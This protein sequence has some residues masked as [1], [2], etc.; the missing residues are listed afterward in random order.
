MMPVK[1]SFPKNKKMLKLFFCE[2]IHFF[3]HKIICFFKSKLFLKSLYNR[4]FKY[5]KITALTSIFGISTCLFIPLH[6]FAVTITNVL[7]GEQELERCR[8]ELTRLEQ[9]NR[10]ANSAALAKNCVC[11]STAPPTDE[12][13]TF[14][15][16]RN[17]TREQYNT[18]SEEC[19]DIST[20]VGNLKASQDQEEK[21][22]ERLQTV[23]QDKQAECDKMLERYEN[24]QETNED[25]IQE[26]EDA[27]SKLRE[28]ETKA[29]NRFSEFQDQHN[30]KM[31]NRIKQ[32]EDAVADM[33]ENLKK[34]LKN[35]Q[36][37]RDA[38]KK[39]L[40]E[41]E[42]Q[43]D[44][45]QAMET[46][47]F[48]TYRFSLERLYASCHNNTLKKIQMERKVYKDRGVNLQH[49]NMGKMLS[50]T[51]NEMKTLLRS[52][53]YRAFN[54]CVNQGGQ[55]GEKG[56]A[57]TKKNLKAQL[58]RALH[59]VKMQRKHLTKEMEVIVKKINEIM[60]KDRPD[61]IQKWQGK[62]QR[63]TNHFNREYAL[64]MNRAQ[65]K[66][67]QLQQKIQNL[68]QKQMMLQK[69]KAAFSS[70]LQA[71]NVEK[72]HHNNCLQVL[73]AIESKLGAEW[74]E[75]ENSEDSD[76]DTDDD[77]FGTS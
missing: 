9:E 62:M 74:E 8:A 35:S 67:S 7:H 5:S 59:G 32:I 26:Q 60:Q 30:E 58:D 53:F 10:D 1:T 50:M 25:R 66:Q 42:A 14:C 51:D 23:K 43:L 73:R 72:A 12:C 63:E 22:Q 55:A 2:K 65:K 16:N 36:R 31:K 45:I 33:E 47:A 21:K 75:E 38:L 3:K 13:Q 49:Q 61:I 48:M 41:M 46:Q 54:R 44:K 28:Q 57:T 76:E 20:Q 6:G 24:T 18:K 68:K 77:I 37:Q 69:R 4:F 64:M 56:V 11:A 15:N 17:S 71:V 29:M 39:Q 19:S 27:I 70:K 52:R 40:R 34:D